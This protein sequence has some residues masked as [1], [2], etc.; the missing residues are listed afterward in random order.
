MG[1]PVFPPRNRAGGSVSNGP[2]W[3]GWGLSDENRWCAQRRTD[4]ACYRDT[5]GGDC[6]KAEQQD[7]RQCKRQQR[8]TCSRKACHGERRERASLTTFCLGRLPLRWFT[9][10]HDLFGQDVAATG[11]GAN[12]NGQHMIARFDHVPCG[13]ERL[14]GERKRDHHN[15]HSV[16]KQ[17][18]L[19]NSVHAG[20]PLAVAGALV[21]DDCNK[22]DWIRCCGKNSCKPS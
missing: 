6:R 7:E 13:H 16:P 20:A 15:D 19:A 5:R 9:G 22:N 18:K 11:I 2:L 1:I 17:Q 10:D 21:T 12:C 14:H 8:R 3:A 4:P